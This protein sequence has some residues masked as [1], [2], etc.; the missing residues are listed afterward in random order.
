VKTRTILGV[1]VLAP[2]LVGLSPAPQPAD[3]APPLRYTRNEAFGLGER[4]T[5]DV[6]YKFISAG[7][8]VFDISKDFEYINNRPCYKITFVTASHKSLE[9]LYK[10]KDTYRTYLDVDGIFPWKFEQHIRER[11]YKK[12]HSA[13]F[14][15]VNK[16]AH[17]TDGVFDVPEYVHD[18]VSA[19]YFVRAADLSRVKK[20]EVIRLTNF[21]DSKSHELAVHILGKEQVEVDAGTFNCIVIEPRIASGSPFGFNGRLVMWLSADERKIPIKV[22]TQIPIGSIDASLKHYEG[23]RGPITAKV[24]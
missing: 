11:N 2:L 15:Q 9:F 4:L 21:V 19:F 7:T 13:T 10:V 5:Y 22:S 12:D 8:A 16:K 18:M 1:F 6:G 17:T 14:D 20:G 24:R 23:T 3:G